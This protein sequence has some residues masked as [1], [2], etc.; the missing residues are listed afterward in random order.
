MSNRRFEMYEYRQII[1]RLRQGDTL[2]GIAQSGLA[3]RKK[4]R[5]IRRIALQQGWLDQR[6][7]IP[8]DQTL[9]QF[10]HRLHRSSPT[11][12][13]VLPYQQQVEEWV[14]QGIQASTI[15]AALQRQHGFRGMY[16]A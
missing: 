8:D 11:Q 3:N 5:V 15:H 7:D 12:S 9:S 13:S 10:F 14:K 4:V 2:R 16:D 1:V 6:N